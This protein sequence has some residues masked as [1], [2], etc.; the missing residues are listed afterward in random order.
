M[1]PSQAAVRSRLF[2]L[3]I[4]NRSLRIHSNKFK[5]HF[6]KKRIFGEELGGTADG[7]NGRV[8][9]RWTREEQDFR[10]SKA[11]EGAYWPAKG[12]I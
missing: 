11:G 5:D 12:E 4:F 7:K 2:Y 9:Y 6:A 10:K 1:E 8:R 3:F